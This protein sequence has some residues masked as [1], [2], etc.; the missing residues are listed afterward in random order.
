MTMK[1]IEGIERRSNCPLSCTLELIGD[2]WSLLII[3]DML[4]FGKTTYNEFLNSEEKI[5]T[6]ILNNRLSKLCELGLISYTGLAKRKKYILTELGM[7]LKPGIMS[8]AAFG[9]KHF[10]GTHRF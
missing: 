2:K 4:L 9:M 7:E 3:R 10:E 1:P 6:N 8:I 5:A